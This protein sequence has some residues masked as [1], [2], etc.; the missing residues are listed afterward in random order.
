MNTSTD[1]ALEAGHAREIV[2]GYSLALEHLKDLAIV[3]LRAGRTEAAKAHV[4]AHDFFI[5]RLNEMEN[6]IELEGEDPLVDVER[7]DPNAD[8]PHDVEPGEAHEEQH[9]KVHPV[10]VRPLAPGHFIGGFHND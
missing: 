3:A 1:I 4:E 9:E 7:I 2:H 8:V 5:A 10:P 6:A